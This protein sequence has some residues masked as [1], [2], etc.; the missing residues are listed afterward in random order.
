MV[1]Y[2]CVRVCVCVCVCVYACVCVC[3]CRHICVY[4]YA[5][6]W[7]CVCVHACTHVCTCVLFIVFICLVVLSVYFHFDSSPKESTQVTSGSDLCRPRISPL[8]LWDCAWEVMA[9]DDGSVLHVLFFKIHWKPCKQ[10]TTFLQHCQPLNTTCCLFTPFLPLALQTVHKS[11]CCNM[12]YVP[13]VE[14][15]HKTSCSSWSCIP[16]NIPSIE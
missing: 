6:M 16:G 7:V 8:E 1:M 2:V 4:A 10:Q 3:T 12:G 14:H 5:C 9:V 15:N 13:L 11:M